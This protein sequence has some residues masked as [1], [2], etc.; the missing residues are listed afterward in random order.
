M[1]S[2][3]LK[4]FRRIRFRLCFLG[5]CHQYFQCLSCCM[6]PIDQAAYFFCDRHVNMFSFGNFMDKERCTH[7]FNDHIRS[8]NDFLRCLSLAH[9]DAG[10]MVAAV[11]ARAGNDKVSHAGKAEEC[12]HLGTESDT[13]SPMRWKAACVPCCTAMPFGH[14]I[15]CLT[16]QAA[17]TKRR[18]L[19]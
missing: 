4:R 7:S 14:G 18:D 8:F 9:H 15:F 12:I 13:E 19:Q 1:N 17:I 11:R 5:S 6:L 10:R 16:M 3:G 2:Y